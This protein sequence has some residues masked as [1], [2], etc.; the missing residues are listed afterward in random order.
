[1]RPTQGRQRTSVPKSVSQ[2]LEILAGLYKE[3]VGQRSVGTSRWAVK[4]GQSLSGLG[5]MA[6]SLAGLRAA[7][8]AGGVVSVPITGCFAA[9]SL[10]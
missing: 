10:A 7:L 1:M 6:L 5:S 2:V 4:S 9:G 8:L 3:N